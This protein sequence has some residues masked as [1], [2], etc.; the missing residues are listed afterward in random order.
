M[1]PNEPPP[2]LPPSLPRPQPFVSLCGEADA[3]C[4]VDGGGGEE[5]TGTRRRAGRPVS[6]AAAVAWAAGNFF[7]PLFVLSSFLHSS[8][9]VHADVE[10]IGGHTIGIVGRGE[11]HN[12]TA[13]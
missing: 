5:G 9:V 11:I 13:K 6:A 2:S 1:G 4:A 3:E 10:R 8:S 12:D 7:P